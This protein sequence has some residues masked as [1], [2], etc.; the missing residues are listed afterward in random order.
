MEALGALVMLGH[1]FPLLG[2]G[3]TPDSLCFLC[4]RLAGGRSS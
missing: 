1:I 4:H 2:Y 3:F